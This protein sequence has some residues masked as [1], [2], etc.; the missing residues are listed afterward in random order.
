MST[1]N[2]NIGFIETYNAKRL[3]GLATTF[4]AIEEEF[5]AT[6]DC[7]KLTIKSDSFHARCIE[8]MQKYLRKD[9]NLFSKYFTLTVAAQSCIELFT[10]VEDSD[11]AKIQKKKFC[12]MLVQAAKLI[13]DNRLSKEVISTFKHYE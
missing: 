4:S 3:E 11:P 12:V 10:K 5:V 7:I 9:T 1:E 2:N 8:R 13:D 6:L